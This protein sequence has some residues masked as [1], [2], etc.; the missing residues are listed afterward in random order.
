MP[1][2]R[3]FF[4]IDWF[5][6]GTNSGGPVRSL[7]NLLPVLSGFEIYIF[8]RNIDYCSTTPYSG[9][10]PS[11][12]T[13]VAPGVKVF[14]ADAKSCNR[15][16]IERLLKSVDPS[17][18]YISGVY[19][20]IFSIQVR[21]LAVKMGLRCVVAPRGMLSPHSTAVKPVK[22]YVYLQLMRLV[23]GYKMVHFHVTSVAEAE[24]IKR[25][26]PVNAGI[27][28]IQNLPRLATSTLR[29]IKKI[30]GQLKLVYI[31]RIAPEKG[32]LEA[33]CSL[34]AIKGEVQL[35]LYGACYNDSYWKLCQHAISVLPATVQVV[36]RGICP[37]DQ[38]SE[39][40]LNAHAL[41]LPSHGE[42]YGHAIVESL[43]A[44]RP[45]LISTKTP[46]QNLQAYKAG[47]DCDPDQLARSIQQLMDMDDSD[48]KEWCSGARHYYNIHIASH[49]DRLISAYHKLF[50][51]S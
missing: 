39:K 37:S 42:N 9:I 3:L 28:I 49:Q 12:W 10:M 27:S 40:L 25:V 2:K 24:D 23:Q 41:L 6:P 45:V 35:D 15:K 29:D 44:A 22:K 19:S 50:T 20:R 26:A 46:W 5:L 36:H 17:V 33:I 31:S 16:A 32:T 47:F 30:P 43:A 51:T 7:A 18:V 38:V 11:C 48:Y 14:Y 4:S 1:K 8:T 34:Q 21:R 13:D